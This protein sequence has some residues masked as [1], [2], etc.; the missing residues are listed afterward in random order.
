MLWP[1]P[2]ITS[3][4]KLSIKSHDKSATEDGKELQKQEIWMEERARHFCIF[5]VF[6]VTCKLLESCMTSSCPYMELPTE[7]IFRLSMELMEADHPVGN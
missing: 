3:F 6:E 4:H 1:V 5:I 2:P 7:Q